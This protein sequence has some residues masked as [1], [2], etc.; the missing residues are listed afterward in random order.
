MKDKI[1]DNKILT[2][3]FLCFFTLS[4]L[5]DLHIF[6]NSISTLIRSIIIAILFI[7]ILI[8]KASKK[9][10]KHFIIYFFILGIYILAHHLNAL[11]FKSYMPNNF[12]Y[13]LL[14]ELLYFFKML[15]NIMLFFIVYKL[16]IK[17]QDIKKYLKLIIF[18]ITSSI[19]I[20]DLLSISYTAYNFNNTTIPIYKWFSYEVYDFM[21]GSSKGFFHLTNQIVAILLLYLPISCYEAYKNNKITDYLIQIM[22]I[23]AMLM[24]G[25]RLAIYGTIIVLFLITLIYFILSIKKKGNIKSYILNIILLI[26]ILVIIPYSPLAMRNKYYDAIYSGRPLN[27]I[28]SGNENAKQNISNSSDEL[29]ILMQ[30][31]QIDPNFYNNCYPYKYDRGFWEKI[32]K[33]DVSLTGNARFMELSMVKRAKEVNNNW[34]D[35]FLGITYTRVM[36]IFNI[37]Q[38]FVMQYYSI[39][40]IGS[41]LL[42]G[43]YV[44][45]LIY[46]G[47]R[48]IYDL[49]F[50]FNI[51]NIA[52]LFG[53]ELFL[54]SSFYSGNILNAISTIIPFSVILSILVNE[55][56]ERKNMQDKEKIL[57]FRVC[58][59]SKEKLVDKIFN[60]LDKQ[61][62]IVNIN[63]LII[64]EHYKDKTKK[65]MFNEQL[66]QIPDG[67]GIVFASKLRGGN[68]K[69][70]IAG[71]DFMLDICEKS[72]ENR[73]KIYLYGA[74][75]NV[76]IKAKKTLEKKYPNINI[77]GTSHGYENED[78]VIKDINK[79][80][81]EILFI[82]L[83][84]P[85]QEDFILRNK[86]K[87]KSIKVFMPVGGSFDVISGNL[88]RAPQV[89]QKLKLE[90]LYRMV[91]EPK[92]LKGIFRLFYFLILCIFDKER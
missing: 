16:N 88:K 76:A 90:W 84:S 35:N 86:D 53:C 44:V 20:S 71:I 4:I 36:N 22:I 43:L 58:T 60:N 21:S 23:I 30:E 80:R 57:G 24:M 92:R 41:L 31:K 52:L 46:S 49:K 34:L 55:V 64:L 13:S 45:L 68:I 75:E 50:K 91:K 74:K 27:I 28:S 87:L 66:I 69:S 14:S 11:N 9:E 18:F 79:K 73:N 78:I 5:F 7:I 29:V 70:R 63:P 32:V 25:N 48:I 83:G 17:Y 61:L 39:G 77:V 85:K 54:I 65:K 2:N 38:D 89:I 40:L 15:S 51:K 26:C 19:I 6:Y 1:L 59:E 81:P 67:E 56:K 47:I 42:L 37:E 82:A 10:K 8:F 12:D 33:N 62:F 3:I 72:A